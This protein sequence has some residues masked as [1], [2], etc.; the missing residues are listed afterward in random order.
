MAYDPYTGQILSVRD[1]EGIETAYSYNRSGVLTGVS[2]GG[3]LAEAYEYDEKGQL[4]R[5]TYAGGLIQEREY[6]GN[7]NC[8][9]IRERGSAGNTETGVR[10]RLGICL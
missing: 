10:R 6:D 4:I 3:V 5:T 1:Y 8:I 9:L 2:R 7:G